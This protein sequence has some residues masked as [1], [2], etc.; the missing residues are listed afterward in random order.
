MSANA[1]LFTISNRYGIAGIESSSIPFPSESFT[2]FESKVFKF[3]LGICNVRLNS[4]WTS[5][6]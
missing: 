3:H 4:I 1:S 5:V 2:S 6:S